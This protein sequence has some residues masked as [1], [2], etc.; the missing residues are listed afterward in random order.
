MTAEELTRQQSRP[1][2]R[3][4]YLAEDCPS[5]PV[6]TFHVSTRPFSDHE[7]NR[8]A[9]RVRA[10]SAAEAEQILRDQLNAERHADLMAMDN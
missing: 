1:A 9:H 2:V 8:R 10:T 5:Y 6:D 4:Y 7:T 3:T